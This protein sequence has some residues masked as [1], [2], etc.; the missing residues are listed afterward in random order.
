MPPMPPPLGGRPLSFG[1]SSAFGHH[2]FRGD[3]GGSRDG[4][5]VL[6]RHAHDLVGSMMPLATRS[7]SIRSFAKL[8]PRSIAPSQ[9]ILPARRSSRLDARVDRDLSDQAPTSARR[10]D[11]DAGL[12]AV[13]GRIFSTAFFGSASGATPPPGTMPSSPP[14][15]SHALA[16]S[17]RSCSPS[18]R[19][20]SRL[21]RGSPRRRRELRQTLLRA[22]HGAQSEVVSS[23]CA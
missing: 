18:L 20:R 10:H 4:G 8:K 6:D 15:G 2:F 1:S 19:L 17:T 9:G 5:R 23:I 14:H 3:R 11:L 16:S 7:T 21:R 12:G 13:V 22:S